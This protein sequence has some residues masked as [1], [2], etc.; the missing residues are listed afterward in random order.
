MLALQKPCGLQR[1]PAQRLQRAR[2]V[3]CK[4]HQEED[5][6]KKAIAVPLASMVAAALVAGALVMPE[7]AL[8]ASRSGGRVGGSSGFSSRKAAA[9]SRSVRTQAA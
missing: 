6:L 8:A 5:A 7:E 4:A 3:V 9:P 2:V 1:L